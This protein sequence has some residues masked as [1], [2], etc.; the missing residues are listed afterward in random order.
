MTGIVLFV[1][2]L[3]LVAALAAVTLMRPETLAIVARKPRSSTAR[4]PM[5]RSPHDVRHGT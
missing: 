5:A 3:G 4:P 2:A 1:I